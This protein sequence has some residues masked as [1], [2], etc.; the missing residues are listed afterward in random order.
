MGSP[1]AVGIDNDLTASEASITLRST[2]D[3]EAGG[4][5]LPKSGDGK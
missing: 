4:L 3:E 5:D 2:D 1:S